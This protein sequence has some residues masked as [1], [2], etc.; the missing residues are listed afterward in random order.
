MY[1]IFIN[2][3]LHFLWFILLY[4]FLLSITIL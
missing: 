1:T 3:I 4:L 2:K